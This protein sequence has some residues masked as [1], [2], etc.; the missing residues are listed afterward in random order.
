M[1]EF[2]IG[3]RWVS[4]SEPELGLGIVL[5]I[6]ERRITI[7]FD[8]AE[9]ERLFTADEAPLSRVAFHAGDSIT[10]KEGQTHTVEEVF[11]HNNLLFY[12]TTDDAMVCETELSPDFRQD[13]AKTRL[14]SGQLDKGKWFSLRQQAWQ[15][16]GQW[17][18][19]P[20]QGF[21]GVRAEPL[22]HQLYIAKEV[23]DRQAPRVMLAD[24]VGLGKTIEAG[25]ILS[26]RWLKFGPSTTLILVPHA[27][28]F[29][30]F[31]E[32][33]RRFNLNASLPETAE[34]IDS[35]HQLIIA[36]T[37]WL[38][39]AE[40]SASLL[41][42][43]PELVII[44]EAQHMT[45]EQAA[46]SRVERLARMAPGFILISATPE[47]LGETAH[48]ARLRLLEPGQFDNAEKLAEL[49]ADQQHMAE[50][51]VALSEE[52]ETPAQ[53]A[54]I[55]KLTGLSE[56]AIKSDH[57]L[58]LD[59]LVDR[60]GTGRVLF[61]NLRRNIPGF[62]KREL[63]QHDTDSVVDWVCTFVAEHK[64]EKSLV[65][66]R[67][68]ALLDEI[69]DALWSKQGLHAALMH[70]GQ[71]LD[72][73]DR[74]AAYFA[75]PEENVPV[76]LTTE[77]GAEGRNFQFCQHLVMADLPTQP[78]RLEQRIGRLDRIGQL[79]DIQIHVPTVDDTAR[80]RLRWF[81]EALGI[82]TR[83]NPVA[84]R[85]QKE[86]M[87]RVEKYVSKHVDEAVISDARQ[88]SD[89]LIAAMENGRDVLLERASCRQPYAAQL[90]EA[91]SAQTGDDNIADFVEAVLNA[92][93][94]FYE[95]LDDDT[96]LIQP[97]DNMLVPSL[98][99]LPSE[100][101]TFTTKRS[102]A[103]ARDDIDLLTWDHPLVQGLLEIL[104][105]GELGTAAVMRFTTE[106][107]PAGTILLEALI[108][109][110]VPG[111]RRFQPDQYH[112]PQTLRILT[113]ATGTKNLSAALPG[114]KLDP[115]LT[116][117]P[118]KVARQVLQMKRD[119]LAT[120][121]A[122]L[123]T[124]ATA[125]L[126]GFSQ[127]AQQAVERQLNERLSQLQWI[128]SNN[129]LFDQQEVEALET[130]RDAL[131]SALEGGAQLHIDA[132]RLIVCTPE[133]H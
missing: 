28:R 61:R 94:V 6:D 70:D 85:V 95:Q 117:I 106:A 45:P 107:L 82:F 21:T 37:N 75:D 115:L 104:T 98:P 24:E 77:I 63:V 25:Y 18:Q 62:P 22:A 89:E 100:G 38:N 16:F 112:A 59:R 87:D 10:D 130:Q 80:A 48:L 79:H 32:L 121:L 17:S 103:L 12:R 73:L 29:Q 110:R 76:L 74:V 30:W 132:L 96:M 49:E 65:I 14:L 69:A 97:V 128:A 111:P 109:L 27:L 15:H 26:R 9:T 71:R 53:L 58:A 118:K 108:T 23:A 31:V 99:G 2:S 46:F 81:D 91:V 84:S 13:N 55:V 54:D 51:A 120:M 78:D 1:S 116:N 119:E 44:D 127:T 105:T 86:F 50:L 35:N 8:A 47:Q 125:D 83:P 57:Q 4:Q 3:Q 11:E 36:P 102:V 129:P 60:H 64:S 33:K 68:K 88:R 56:S 92:L 122:A 90:A 5:K 123:P 66:A 39:D 131:L 114:E 67:S 133:D 93:N 124:L 43:M 40:A 113:E 20:V 19:S 34:D 41:M 72:E 52:N 126:D 101:K 42:L 7:A